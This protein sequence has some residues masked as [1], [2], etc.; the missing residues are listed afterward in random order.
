MKSWDTARLRI[1]ALFLYR[2]SGQ[3]AGI[4]RGDVSLENEG[5]KEQMEEYIASDFIISHGVVCG[6]SVLNPSRTSVK[7]FIFCAIYSL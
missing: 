3:L 7:S 1:Q 4:C 2:K 5:R 6:D